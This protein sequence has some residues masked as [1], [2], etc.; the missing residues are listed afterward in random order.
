MP[1]MAVRRLTDRRAE[2]R[3]EGGNK[4]VRSVEEDVWKSEECCLNGRSY[5][6][7]WGLEID[8]RNL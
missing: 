8:G 3:V 4:K 7:R 5:S 6:A 2:R 1:R